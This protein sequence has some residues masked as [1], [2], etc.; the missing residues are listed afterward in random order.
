MKKKKKEF[1]M[2]GEG[3]FVKTKRPIT[4]EV[5]RYKDESN[6]QLI[7]RFIRDFKKNKV[8]DEY[9]KSVY[10]TKP[11]MLKRKAKEKSLRLMREITQYYEEKNDRPANYKRK[12]KK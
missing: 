8:M 4:T 9:K 11:S 2:Y 12:E 3:A 5:I 10:Y 1:R 6:E 7:T